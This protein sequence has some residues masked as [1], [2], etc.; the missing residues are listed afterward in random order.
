MRTIYLCSY[1][2]G[3]V[4]ASLVAYRLSRINSSQRTLKKMED[5]T[6]EDRKPLV[7]ERDKNPI[8]VAHF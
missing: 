6:I 4:E 7:T 3:F 8:S 1:V 5:H 2:E